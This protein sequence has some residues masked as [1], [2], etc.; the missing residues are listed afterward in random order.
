MPCPTEGCYG[1]AADVGFAMQFRTSGQGAVQTYLAISAVGSRKEG[2][3]KTLAGVEL[4]GDPGGSRE[5]P[6]MPADCWLPS[7][8]RVMS[9]AFAGCRGPRRRPAT[10]KWQAL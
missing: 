5:A 1:R 10:V 8:R 9:L 3:W 4:A 7:W 2:T 6:V